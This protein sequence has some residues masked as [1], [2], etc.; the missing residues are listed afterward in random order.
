M[1]YYSEPPYFLILVGLL[2][3]ITCGL[4]FQTVLKQ[5]VKQW[6]KQ[7]S[8]QIQTNLKTPDIYI[9]FGGIGL[10]ICVFLASGLGIFGVAPWIA[11]GISL[12][13]TLFVTSLIWFQLTEMLILLERG[14][15]QSLDLDS[16]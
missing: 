4:A 14:G 11:Y 15:S 2:I 3:G 8:L 16:F 6:T 13:L 9:P 5:K 7:S 12:L 10:G 1:Y